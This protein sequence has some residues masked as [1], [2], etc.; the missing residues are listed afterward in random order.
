MDIFHLIIIPAGSSLAAL[1]LAPALAGVVNRTKARVAGRQGPPIWQAYA[2]L[3]RLARKGA[4]FSP[5]TSWV[6]RLAPAV[7]FCATLAATLLVPLIRG[8]GMAGFPGDVILFLYLLALARFFLIIAALD[9][10][11]AFEGMGASREAFFSALAEPVLLICLLTA[12]RANQAGTLA[13][14]LHPAVGAGE[15]GVL[16]AAVPL[17]AVLLAENARIP[18]DDPTTHLELTMIHEVMILDHSG[19]DLALLEYAAAIKLWLFAL[20]P[21]QLLLPFAAWPPWV[22][23]LALAGYMALAGVV[24]GLVESVMARLRLRKIPPLLVGA[25]ALALVGFFVTVTQ[26]GGR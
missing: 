11:S 15:A 22:Q 23:A 24:I 16:V 20:L 17:L 10:G 18:F 19:P 14:A 26:V 21:G 1:A 2:D 4:V 5:T 7:I 6:F 13:G 3:W 8:P 9:T 12:M 25:G